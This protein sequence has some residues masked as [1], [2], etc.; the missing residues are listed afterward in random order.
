[1]I[2]EICHKKIVNNIVDKVLSDR[3]KAINK[4]NERSIDACKK[5]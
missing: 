3:T 5:R 1:M 2:C 4:L